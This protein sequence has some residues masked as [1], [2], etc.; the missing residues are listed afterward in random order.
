MISQFYRILE[1]KDKIGF[2]F[3]IILMAVGGIFE[4]LSI[5]ILIP[6]ISFLLDPTL[7]LEH[8]IVLEHFSFLT[9]IDNNILIYYLLAIIFTS[10]FL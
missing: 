1:K 9:R 10:F 5:G 3:I 4:T 8:K 7:L 2:I 6:F